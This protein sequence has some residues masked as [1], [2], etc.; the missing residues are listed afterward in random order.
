[1]LARKNKE[2]TLK[3]YN[4]WYWYLA[5]LAS[6]SIIFNALLVYR[7]ELLGYQTFSIPSQSMVPTL[8]INDYITVDTRSRKAT[9]GDII[10]FSSPQNQDVPFVKRVVA[11]GGDTLSI[12]NGIIIRNGQS[13]DKLQVPKDRRKS[14]YAVTMDEIKIP[15]N[16]FFVLGDWR[17]KSA[18]SRIWGTVPDKNIIGKVR[19][20]W[21]S[22]NLKR[23]GMAVK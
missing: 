7:G 1:M 23:I 2:Y 4:R 12:K 16:E 14:K 6:V 3:P 19:Y 17:D 22:T 9:V 15:E 10:V 13:E 11:V 5:F 20:I 18:D 8:K 21:L